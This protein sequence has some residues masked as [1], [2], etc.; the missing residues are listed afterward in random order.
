MSNSFTALEID[1]LQKSLREMLREPR[2]AHL[3]R[4]P[5]YTRVAKKVDA[6][7]AKSRRNRTEAAAD[8]VSPITAA[9]GTKP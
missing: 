9:K 7:A 1:W 6:M 8:N 5:V 4:L 3:V 2:M